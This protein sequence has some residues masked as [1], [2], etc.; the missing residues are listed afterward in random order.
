MHNCVDF[1]GAVYEL[2]ITETANVASK[3][4][5]LGKQKFKKMGRQYH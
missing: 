5:Y 3:I 2:T 4:V 1:G